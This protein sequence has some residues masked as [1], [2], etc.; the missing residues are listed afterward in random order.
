SPAGTLNGNYW[1]VGSIATGETQSITIVTKATETG[2]IYNWA[3]IGGS[4]P[5]TDTSNNSDYAK[6]H[7]NVA[8]LS[9]EKTV[10]EP[11]AVLGGQ[12]VWTVKVSNTGGADAKNVV[13]T[14]VLPAGLTLVSTDPVDALVNNAWTVGTG[15]AGDE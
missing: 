14:D 2:T 9:V 12:A 4:T 6:I 15:A 11:T 10:A 5:D 8:K 3:S 13:V 7:V 1:D